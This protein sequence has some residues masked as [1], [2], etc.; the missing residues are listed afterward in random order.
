LAVKKKEK[1]KGDAPP[2]PPRKAQGGGGG[3]MYSSTMSLTSALDGDGWLTPRAGR[4]TPGRDPI[5]LVQK[6]GSDP[7]PVWTA[8]EDLEP[9]GI[10]SVD[11]PYRSESL[12]RLSCRGPHTPPVPVLYQGNRLVAL[13][14]L[15]ALHNILA[16]SVY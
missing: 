10:R 1:E 2:K 13:S 12:Y 16:A 6:P 14:S 4:L 15:V 3:Q 7:A 8:T 11:R 9:T 5:R